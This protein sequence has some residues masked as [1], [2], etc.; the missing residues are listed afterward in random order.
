MQRMVIGSQGEQCVDL[1]LNEVVVRMRSYDQ[2]SEDRRKD[3]VPY[4]HSI[5][6]RRII[7]AVYNQQIE[8]E[9]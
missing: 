1:R 4:G 8:R 2:R 6:T 3:I 7:L 5:Y 9:S